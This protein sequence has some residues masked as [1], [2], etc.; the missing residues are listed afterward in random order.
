LPLPASPA[1][2]CL[3]HALLRLWLGSQEFV[4]VNGLHLVDNEE[5]SEAGRAVYPDG[6]YKLLTSFHNRYA[7]GAPGLECPLQRPPARRPDSGKHSSGR[8]VWSSGAPLAPRAGRYRKRHPRLRYMVTENGI[9][10]ADDHIRRLYLLEHL[11][12]LNAAMQQVG[13]P[14]HAFLQQVRASCTQAGPC[15]WP[16]QQGGAPSPGSVRPR[17]K[18][19]GSKGPGARGAGAGVGACVRGRAQG[20]PVDA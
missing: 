13:A 4:S 14:L 16:L 8:E 12:S 5:Y 20:V 9:A 18:A 3:Y 15:M 1:C 7:C 19:G 10:D 11:A 2:S 17:A 6:L